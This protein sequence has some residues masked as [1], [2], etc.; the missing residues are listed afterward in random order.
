MGLLSTEA[1]A[2][3]ETGRVHLGFFA[4]LDFRSGVERYW[5]GTAPITW[6]GHTWTGTGHL[7]GVGP[8]ESSS[9]FR[10]NGLALTV[11]GLPG[12]A[13]TD[14]DAV[15]ASDYKGRSARFIIAIMDNAFQTVVHAI[16]RNFSIDTVD[17]A[18]DPELGGV[19][20][21]N[22]EVETRRASRSRVRRYTPQ[23][24]QAAFP[25]DKALEFVPYLNSGVE[26]KWGRGGA[27][28]KND[29]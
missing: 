19:V 3:L 23:D 6:D 14:F 1:K 20:T 26:V 5:S 10:A 28:F 22:L 16:Q 15:T 9:D 25:G 8:M 11:A 24:Q 4:E 18:L 2:I 12:D 13:F 29:P 27:F 7:G 17:Y 21:V